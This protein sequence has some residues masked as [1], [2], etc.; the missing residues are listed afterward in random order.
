[1]ERAA[2]FGVYDFIG[3]SLCRHMLDIGIEVEGI[4][5]AGEG[6]DYYT[7][8]K[9]LEIGRNANFIETSLLDWQA[10]ETE[11]FL[12]ITLFEAF[13]DEDR[14]VDFL[15]TLLTKLEF[16]NSKEMSTV[17]VL[18]AYFAQKNAKLEKA[19][20]ELN[21]FINNRLPS[22]LTIYLPTIYGPWQPGKFFFQQVM[23]HSS[24]EIRELPDV[25][26]LEWTDDCLYIDDAV[27]S[28]REMAE[29]G[30]HGQ[31]LL[32]SGDSGRW[33]ACV[34]ELLGKEP[35]MPGCCVAKPNFKE[36]IKFSK[37]ASNEEVSRGL[38]K[39]REQYFRIQNS[40]V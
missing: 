27:K 32:S 4:H 25:S 17:V 23:N 31:F 13:L 18:P 2:I 38:S 34:R 12:F 22:I 16:R 19:G 1:M 20:V 24:N 15:E 9:R 6:E 30:K 7:E 28:I 33:K 11:D 21:R 29:S 3:Y 36:T 10:V 35:A 37:V 8:E 40:R 39:Q 26:Q 5:P 14:T